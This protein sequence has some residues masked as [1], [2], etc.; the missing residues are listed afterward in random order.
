ME[1]KKASNVSR[2]DFL[3]FAATASAAVAGTSVLAGC[4]ASKSSAAAADSGIKWDKETEVLVCGYGAA[5]SAAAIDAAEAGAKVLIIEKAALPGGSM[6][7]CGGAIQG[8]GTKVQ[9]ALGITDSVDL[10]YDWVNKCTNQ[11][12]ELCPTDIIKVYAEKSGPVVDWLEQMCKDY[13]DRELFEYAVAVENEQAEGAKQGGGNGVTSGCLNAVG[14]EWE[15]FGITEEEAIPRSHWAH[16]EP[17]TTA[18][19]GP[20][21]FEPLYENINSKIKEKKITVEYKTALKELITNGD[22][23]VI[24]VV[25]TTE[26]GDI[27]IKATK[28]VMLATGGF[29]AGDDMKMRFLQE[30]LGYTTYMCYDCTG[31]GIK[32]A[33]GIGADLYNMC[34]FYP[35][36][37]AQVYHYNV[38]YNDVFNSWLDMDDEG[39]MNVPAPNMA[40]CHGGVKINVDAQ[41]MDIE[42]KVIPHLYASG[43]DVGTNIWGV[44][45]N[46]PGCGSYVAFSMVFGRIAGE[47]MAA[48]TAIA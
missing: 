26:A 3:K 21:L 42:G 20:E 10:M 34:N 4:T 11:N 37:V 15:K 38:Q 22:G 17:D 28:G 7:R 35:I 27:N 29:T 23:A 6:A 36:P 41:V 14:C 25:A 8:A 2:R 19:S 47:K 44:P 31:D 16:A 24:G 48:E 1:D 43:C 32:A 9:K 45:G 40:E 46:Y 33:M 13:C 39:Y 30:A 18:N 5:G 12:Y